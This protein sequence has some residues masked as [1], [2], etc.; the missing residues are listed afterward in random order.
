MALIDNVIDHQIGF[1]TSKNVVFD[2]SKS[3]LKYLEHN[4]IEPFSN[5][6]EIIKKELNE[7]DGKE[8]D[9]HF[10]SVRSSSA[11]CVNNFAPFKEHH[12]KL[13]FLGYSGFEEAR[14]E[15]KQP[16]GLIRQLR[17]GSKEERTPNLD[18]YLARQ[19]VAIGIES[20]FA[21]HFEKPTMSLKQSLKPYLEGWE[22]LKEYLSEG[23]RKEILEHYSDA[24][25]PQR[26]DVAQLIKHAIGLL[27]NCGE[28]EPILVYLYWEPLN[29]TIDNL[30]AEHRHNVEMFK[31]RIEHFIEFVPLS[32]PE[33]W[34]LYKDDDLLKGHIGRIRERYEFEIEILK[35]G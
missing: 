20:K 34:K 31:H 11:L 15:K 14:F 30:F 27:K 18:F 17:D 33:F 16:T 32:Y 4:L 28:K 29:P 7:G 3:R 6:W 21:E 19:E 10:F 35:N 24:N 25:R 1:L 23:F 13:S 5:V 2:K 12:K 26:L 22:T 8:L 9:S